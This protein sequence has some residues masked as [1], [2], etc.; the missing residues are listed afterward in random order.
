MPCSFCRT[1]LLLVISAR[2]YPLGSPADSP[3]CA[4]LPSN[5]LRY[6]FIKFFLPFLTPLPRDAKTHTPVLQLTFPS[7][8]HRLQYT[9][10]TWFHFVLLTVLHPSQMP[11][12]TFSLKFYSGIVFVCCLAVSLPHTLAHTGQPLSF[13]AQH[14]FP[15]LF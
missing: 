10:W 6:H 14:Y 2:L 8:L 13:P 4:A 3:P 7:L 9:K 15:F 12:N 1:K 5:F 11:A